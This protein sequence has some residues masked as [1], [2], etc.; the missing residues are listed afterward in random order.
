MRATSRRLDL[1]SLVSGQRWELQLR[2]GE[3]L[4]VVG[5]ELGITRNTKADRSCASAV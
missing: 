5:K 3:M 4:P 1:S 2:H